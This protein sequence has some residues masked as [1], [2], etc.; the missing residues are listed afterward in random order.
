M[1]YFRVIFISILFGIIISL[2]FFFIFNK[3]ENLLKS[4]E[5]NKYKITLEIESINNFANANTYSDDFMYRNFLTQEL[6]LLIQTCST[7]QIFIVEELIKLNNFPAEF[8]EKFIQGEK[9]IRLDHIQ[10]LDTDSYEVQDVGGEYEYLLINSST[11]NIKEIEKDIKKRAGI[12]NAYLYKKI[13]FLSNIIAKYTRYSFLLNP[14]NISGNDAYETFCKPENF[15]NKFDKIKKLYVEIFDKKIEI[16]NDDYKV[17]INTYYQLVEK[18]VNGFFGL[19]V[20]FLVFSVLT[21]VLITQIRF[22]L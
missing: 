15:I 18:Y 3:N 7:K 12:I 9:S 10:T 13:D 20:I 16:N 1:K 2:A 4:L 5:I 14:Y 6:I 11:K 8:L 22:L 17:E 21:F 19:F